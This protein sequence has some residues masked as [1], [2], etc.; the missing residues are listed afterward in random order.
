MSI[1][2]DDYLLIKIEVLEEAQKLIAKHPTSSAPAVIRGLTEGYK[3][4]LA[5]FQAGE[6]DETEEENEEEEESP[7]G[8]TGDETSCPNNEGF[9]CTCAAAIRQNLKSAS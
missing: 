7:A 3:S 1:A 5:L 6:E 2:L 9:G 4:S 8:C